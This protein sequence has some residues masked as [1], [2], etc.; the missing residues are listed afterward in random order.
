MLV[1]V[2]AC[3]DNHLIDQAVLIYEF[4]AFAQKLKRVLIQGFL[5]LPGILMVSEAMKKSEG[6]KKRGIDRDGD[7]TNRW[8][9]RAQDK[10][11]RSTN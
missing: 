9:R 2:G 6:G 8:W 10:T 5:D 3:T 7:G 1:P 11:I 4:H